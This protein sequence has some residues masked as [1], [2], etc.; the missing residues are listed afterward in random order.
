MTDTESIRF[1]AETMGI[2]FEEAEQRSALS[3]AVLDAAEALEASTNELMKALTFRLEGREDG[4]DRWQ[5]ARLVFDSAVD[6]FDIARKDAVVFIGI[7]G[8]QVPQ[9]RS[10]SVWEAQLE[11]DEETLA[12]AA[13]ALL[14]GTITRREFEERRSSLHRARAKFD[15][16]VDMAVTVGDVD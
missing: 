14:E 3:L 13:S 12:D 7:H 16:E 5:K 1:L 2:E 10:E 15:A 11:A 6:R 8:G 4:D 9:A